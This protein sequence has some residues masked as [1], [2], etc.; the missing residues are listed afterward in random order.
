M[1]KPREED[2]AMLVPVDGQR[3]PLEVDTGTG[4]KRKGESRLAL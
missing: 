3:S 2:E 1:R 4:N